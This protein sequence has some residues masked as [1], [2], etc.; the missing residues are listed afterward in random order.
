VRRV[1]AAVGIPVVVNGDIT[2]MAAAREALAASGADAVMVGR[3]S[4]GRP[5]LP[6]QIAAGLA[7]GRDPGPPQ[8]SRLAEIVRGHYHS[9]LEHYGAE[10]GV[11]NA[12]KH[13]GWYLEHAYGMSEAMKRWRQR[14]CASDDAR[15]VLAGIK[16]AFDREPAEYPA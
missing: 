1:K 16:E 9:M 13:L 5:W 4:Y 7:T 15:E 3:G 11:R 12:R 8:R 2:D 14:L 10:L 6:G